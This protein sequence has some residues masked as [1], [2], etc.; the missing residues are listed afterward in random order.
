M[1]DINIDREITN[2]D[3][4]KI[5]DSLSKLETY[6]KELQK[7]LREGTYRADNSSINLPYDTELEKEVKQVGEKYGCDVLIVIGIGGSNLGTKAVHEAIQTKL[8]NHIATETQVYFADTTH[9][10][11]LR[12]IKKIITKSHSDGKRV[13][14]NTISKSGGTTETI[15]NF[16]YLLEAMRKNEQWRDDVIIT[17]SKG[18]NF[19]KY[20]DNESIETLYIPRKVGGRFSVLSTV[21]LLPLEIMG[22][23]ITELCRGARDAVK[24]SLKKNNNILRSAAVKHAYIGKGSH[25][26]FLFDPDLESLGKWHRQLVGESLGKDGKGVNPTVSIGSTDL[27]SVAQ[28]YLGGCRN[29]YH[30]F[31]EVK[32]YDSDSLPAHEEF[33]NLVKDIQG[34][35]LSKIVSSISQGVKESFKQEDIPFSTNRLERVDEYNLGWWMQYK[36]IEIMLV[37]YLLGINTFNQPQVELYKEETR[38]ELQK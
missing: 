12:S 5:T 34:K 4:N 20:A 26:I 22:V 38:K 29:E 24:Y 10:P 17:T 23:N 33:E 7:T 8:H 21:G 1:T 31:V 35:E 6:Q 32:E 14:F 9:P 18:S 19:S 16:E 36:M 3:E 37:G 15:A 25:N 13:I 27:H 30:E 2:V 28:Y 11:T